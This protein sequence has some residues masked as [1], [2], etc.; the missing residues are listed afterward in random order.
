MLVPKDL[1]AGKLQELSRLNPDKIYPENVRSILGVSHGIAVGI[2]ETAVR[3][4]LFQ[5]GIEVLCPDGTVAAI[6]KTEKELPKIVRCWMEQGGFPEEVDLPTD[7][8]E[9]HKFYRLN[10]NST[11]HNYA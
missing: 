10:E 11:I 7:T 9:K 5:T 8:L 3:Q 4:G 6:A 1:I 2:C